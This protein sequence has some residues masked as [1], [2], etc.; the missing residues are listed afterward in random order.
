MPDLKHSL[1]THDLGFLNIVADFWG[2]EL[3]APDARSALPELI[4]KILDPELIQEIVD[5]L[6][7]S[8]RKALD[9]LVKNEGWMAWSRFVITYGEL[10]EVGPG[11]R[12]REKPFLDPISPTEILWYR[13]LIGRDFLRREGKLKECV[14]IPDDLLDH[15]PAV[16]PSGPELP[17]RPASPR[18]TAHIYPV[19]DR[20]LDH[21]CTLLAAL[22]L[23]DP[24]RSP[25][26][27]DWQPPFFVVYALLAAMKLITSSEQP[28]AEDARP[29]LE[30]PRGEALTWL[31]QRWHE[32]RLFNELRLVTGLSCEGA[33]QNDPF[34]ARE[35]ILMLLSDIPEDK[36]WNLE[37]FINAVFKQEPDFQRPSGDFD[38][39]L[40]QDA[41]TGDSLRGIQH[42]DAVDG[43]LLRFM[44][45][46]P[47]HWLGLLDLAAPAPGE[48]VTAFRFSDWS[49]N[50]LL[51]KPVE[52]LPPEDEIVSA[53]TDGS[54]KV[55][56]L[57]PRLAR[58]QISRFC[59]WEEETSRIYHYQLTP[60]S[61][62]AAS[63]Q[64]LRINHLEK[65]LQRYG[66]AP[67]PNLIQAL[68]RWKQHGGEVLIHPGVILRVNSPKILQ[69]LRESPAGRFIGDPLGPT[70][71]IVFP[72]A[73]RKVAKALARLGYL[74][75]L[76]Q[77]NPDEDRMDQTEI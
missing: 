62:N 12:D 8:A 31:V 36:W 21:T 61:L 72:G 20:V 14:Y 75:D 51:G 2:V 70:S 66:E 37:S 5:S 15:I 24:Q 40:I 76:S 4:N 77:S 39:W 43:A 58:Y 9:D 6:P 60:A 48:P 29:F 17:G 57:V 34:A 10:R 47:M 26:I 46:G 56:R 67:P 22:R 73:E 64:G 65:L 41:E 74:S 53:F 33:W 50:L 45:T 16:A 44:I 23:K 54:L 68:R 30:M 7:T 32:S 25:S 35:K 27:A 55:P 59:S 13:G 52:G 71:A 38:T 1:R 3:H 28:V 49:E 69:A 42:W 18:E 11:R 63:K 19:N